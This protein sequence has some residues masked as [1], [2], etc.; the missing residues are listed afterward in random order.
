MFRRRKNIKLIIALFFIAAAIIFFTVRFFIVTN[1]IARAQAARITTNTVNN[2]ANHF[3]SDNSDLYS[4]II[5]KDKTPDGNIAAINTDIEKINR[6]QTEM[7]EAI[8]KGLSESDGITVKI[9]IGNVIGLPILLNVGPRIS[10]KIAP[11]SNVRVKFED[12]F[13]TAGINQTQFSVN[14]LIDTDVIYSLSAYQNKLS[15]ASTIPVVQLVL[16]G[17][18]PDNYANIE[19]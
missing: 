15:I 16:V 11:V 9:P 17:D 19:R 10:Y 3:L 14:L 7:A 8:L 13:K 5:V 12:S 4:N 18:I 1:E 6:L 2:I